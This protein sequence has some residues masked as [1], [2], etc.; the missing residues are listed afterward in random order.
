MAGLNVGDIVAVSAVG[1]CLAQRVLATMLYRVS[2]PSTSGDVLTA[3]QN[4]A[5][6]YKNN[7]ATAWVT[8]YL[9][10]APQNY[11][12]TLVRAQRIWPTRSIYRDSADGRPGTIAS[13]A[14]TCNL[15][16]VITKR[17]EDGTRKGIGRLHTAPL[18]PTA[19]SAGL[20]SALFTPLATALRDKLILAS[21][22][23]GDATVMGPVLW[24]RV[25]PSL[26]K[27]L[28]AGTVQDTIRTL[29]RRTLR[30]GE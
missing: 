21:T 24:N 15:T 10:A 25:A 18:P 11:T 27:P 6:F 2:G 28:F 12:C 5:D 30:V 16:C 29:R 13:N 23:V 3:L 17:T 9:A 20:I 14:E 1:T 22:I 4:V 19:Q 26:Y 7:G 8:A